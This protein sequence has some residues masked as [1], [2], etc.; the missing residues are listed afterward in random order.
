MNTNDGSAPGASGGTRIVA[1]VLALA[2]LGIVIWLAARDRNPASTVPTSTRPALSTMALPTS[3][4]P[5]AVATTTVRTVP[6][7]TSRQVVDPVS[8]LRWVDEPAL[9]PQARRTLALIRSEGPFPYPRNDGAVYRNLNRVLPRQPAGYYH[10]YTVPTPG[11]S[12]R[13][14]RRIVRGDAGELYYTEDHYDSFVRI[15]EIER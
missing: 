12:N 7:T 5:H 3:S 8:G 9:N 15:R 6:R 11:A 1:I 14:A 10:E 2:V 4:A 13:G